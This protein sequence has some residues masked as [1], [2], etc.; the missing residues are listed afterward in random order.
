MATQSTLTKNS[1]SNLDTLAFARKCALAADDKK[2]SDI[3]IIDVSKL[4]SFADYFVI[5]SAPSER[6]VQAIIGNVEDT[7]RKDGFKP[8]GVEGLETSS[9][10]LIDFGDVIFHCFTDAAREYYDLEGFWIDAP[11]IDI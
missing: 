1:E 8:L 7:M 11:K 9:W 5:C 2:A 10:V 3:R 4:T 6:Q